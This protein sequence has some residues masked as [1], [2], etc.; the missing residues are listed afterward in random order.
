MAPLGRHLTKY[1]THE[2]SHFFLVYSS[3]TSFHG[4]IHSATNS[5]GS[6]SIS[7]RSA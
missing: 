6:N 4:A 1:L 5:I 7:I 2:A 3:I